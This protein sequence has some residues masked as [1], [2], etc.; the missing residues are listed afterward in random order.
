MWFR[1]WDALEQ[2]KVTR[3]V[4][5]QD[6]AALRGGE[7]S[8]RGHP[9]IFRV[10]EMFCIRTGLVARQMYPTVKANHSGRSDSVRFTVC[11]LYLHFPPPPKSQCLDW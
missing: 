11:K 5:S 3:G 9:G 4:G 1:F 6:R 10:L 7:G 8:C 2:A